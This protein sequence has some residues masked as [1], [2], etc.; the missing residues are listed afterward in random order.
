MQKYGIYDSEAKQIICSPIANY[1]QLRS[2]LSRNGILADNIVFDGPQQWHHLLVLPGI[3][4]PPLSPAELGYTGALSHW[5]VDNAK[6]LRKVVWERSTL[7][8]FTDELRVHISEIQET[9]LAILEIGYTEH[10]IK[11]WPQQRAEAAEYTLDSTKEVPLLKGMAERRDIPLATFV[12]HVQAKV[13]A[14]ADLTA[15]ILG[16]AQAADDKIKAIQ[17]LDKADKLP[18]DWFDQLTDIAENWRKEWPAILLVND[19]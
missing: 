16:D 9:S 14:T 8:D 4:E 18:V 15:I 7:T 2:I 10:E 12:E 3:D 5:A 19:A 6:M 1:E 13:K 17:A 11:S